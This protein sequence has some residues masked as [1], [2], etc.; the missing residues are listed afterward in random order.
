MAGQELKEDLALKAVTTV[1]IRWALQRKEGSRELTGEGVRTGEAYFSVE[2]SRFLLSR[3]AEVPQ[4]NGSDFMLMADWQGVRQYIE[5]EQVAKLEASNGGAPIFWLFDVGSH[6]NGLHAEKARFQDIG[7]V[8]DGKAYDGKS[9]F[10]F[11]RGETVRQGQVYTVHC[12]RKD[13]YAKMEI[14]DVTIVA[15]AAAKSSGD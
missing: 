1:G 13:C 5:K 7:A 14:M 15:K 10:K 6:P 9:Y 8:N 12:A 4:A 11:L 2:H 3:G